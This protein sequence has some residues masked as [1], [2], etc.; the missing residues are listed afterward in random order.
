[1]ELQ[2]GPMDAN[3]TS[4]SGRMAKVSIQKPEYRYI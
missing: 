4:M 1:M 3:M 2:R